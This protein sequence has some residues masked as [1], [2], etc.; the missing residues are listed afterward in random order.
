MKMQHWQVT[1]YGLAGLEPAQT[2]V[3]E[4]GPGQVLVRI[5]AASLNFRDLLIIEDG[6]GMPLQLPFTPGSDAS[7]EVVAVGLGVSRWRPG[8]EVI[9]TFWSGWW[10]G[11]RP[12]H[13]QPHGAPG[14]GV[15]ASHAVID[16]HDLVARPRGW[17]H[18]QASLLPCAGLTAWT[19]LVEN[20]AL[21]AGQTVLVHGTGGVALFGLQIARMHGARVVVVT[22]SASKRERVM[23]LGATH[24]VLR[25]D[26]WVKQVRRFTG[27]HGVDHVLETAGGENLGKSMELLAPGGHVAAIGMQAGTEMRLPFYPT[28]VNR[29]TVQ[30]VGV[31]HRRS[32]EELVRAVDANPFEPVVDA[33]FPLD[34]VPD[35]LVR[36]REGAFGKIVVT[37]PAG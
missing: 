3:P 4:P 33:S 32:L 27:D 36:L 12:A 15:L 18:A 10:D 1:R 23:A 34:R 13:S 7:G 17:T 5:K 2:D 31:G 20:G 28:I 14:P 11:E 21:R 16:E 9:N 26:D 35:A 37:M 19:A 6:M 8:D 24:A 22:S 29:A 25:D 30:G